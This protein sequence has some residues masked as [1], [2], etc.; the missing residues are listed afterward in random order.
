MLAAA[1]FASMRADAVR[2]DDEKR[3]DGYVSPGTPC[4]SSFDLEAVIY[5]RRE[6]APPLL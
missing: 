6:H 3:V 4:M 5:S 1:E 2:Q